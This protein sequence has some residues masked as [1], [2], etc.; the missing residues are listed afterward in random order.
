MTMGRIG[1]LVGNVMFPVLLNMGCV[2][3]FYT[4][5]GFMT[6]KYC[7][8]YSI[9]KNEIIALDHAF[10]SSIFSIKTLHV[11]KLARFGG[12]ITMYINL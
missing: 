3:P 11:T 10:G 7:I 5:A 8:F 4:L 9:Y 2:V 12:D 6:G 1:S